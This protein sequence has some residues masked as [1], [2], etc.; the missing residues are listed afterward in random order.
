[1]AVKAKQKRL[2]RLEAN[3]GE[4]KFGEEKS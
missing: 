3:S 4:Q 1:M 2:K